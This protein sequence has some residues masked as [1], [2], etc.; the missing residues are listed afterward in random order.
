MCLSSRVTISVTEVEQ[1]RENHWR[2]KLGLR[3]QPEGE[4]IWN[5]QTLNNFV[6]VNLVSSQ[7]VR[8]YLALIWGQYQEA[9]RSCPRSQTRWSDAERC[10]SLESAGTWRRD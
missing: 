4:I 9:S 8:E 1:C 3:R 5:D 2:I 10:K 7:A 6:E